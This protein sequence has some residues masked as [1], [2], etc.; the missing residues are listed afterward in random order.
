MKTVNP[1]FHF[2]SSD[3][4][5]TIQPSFSPSLPP[6]FLSL[7]PDHGGPNQSALLPLLLAPSSPHFC[8]DPFE[9]NFL[10]HLPLLIIILIL[11]SRHPAIVPSRG[12]VMFTI[13][14]LHTGKINYELR[15]HFSDLEFQIPP[16]PS[17]YSFNVDVGR[18]PVHGNLP[19]LTVT[20]TPETL[21]W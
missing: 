14:L 11:G 18:D 5:T 7:A 4:N 21:F 9:S 10:H 2:L 1:I 15:H 20:V 16:S 17:P 12:H 13:K 19:L 3:Q 6:F 8:R